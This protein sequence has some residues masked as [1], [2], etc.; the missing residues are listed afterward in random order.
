[1]I[2]CKRNFYPPDRLR[3]ARRAVGRVRQVARQHPRRRNQRGPEQR[4]GD[5]QRQADQQARP[6]GDG[7]GQ[8]TARRRDPP[9]R[10][11]L[12]S[13]SACDPPD[14]AVW[15]CAPFRRCLK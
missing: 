15:L 8:T 2:S 5:G 12:S 3:R 13:L 6:R 14:E 1:M 7:H 9:G 10:G 4:V 11:H